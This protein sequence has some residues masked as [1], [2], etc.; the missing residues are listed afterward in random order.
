M[1]AIVWHEKSKFATYNNVL[2][3]QSGWH[4]PVRFD[5]PIASRLASV[6]DLDQGIQFVKVQ[7]DFNSI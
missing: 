4:N 2:A 1:V 7:A 3:I 6:I 5:A